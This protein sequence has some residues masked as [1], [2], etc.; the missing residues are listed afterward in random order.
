MYVHACTCVRVPF[1]LL[2]HNVNI[3]NNL[4]V[5]GVGIWTVAFS[6]RI[7]KALFHFSSVQTGYDM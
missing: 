4:D 6:H 2:E 7:S 1:Q 3:Y 5:T